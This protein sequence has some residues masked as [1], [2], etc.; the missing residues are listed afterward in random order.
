MSSKLFSLILVTFVCS[1]VAAYGADNTL[2]GKWCYK[3]NQIKIQKAADQKLNLKGIAIEE[4]SRSAPNTGDF[5]FTETPTANIVA[6]LDRDGCDVVLVL[7]NGKLHVADNAM[8]GG[9]NVRFDGVYDR[10]E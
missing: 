8:C 1:S 5:D 3:D 4:T 6:H 7:S 9:M 2:E 10:C